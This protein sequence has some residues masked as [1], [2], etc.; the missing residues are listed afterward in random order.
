MKYEFAHACELVDGEIRSCMGTGLSVFSGCYQNRI[1]RNRL[2]T[3][4]HGAIVVRGPQNP[5]DGREITRETRIS[6]NQLYDCGGINIHASYTLM[7][8]ISHNYIT[9]TRGRFA[10]DVGG[11]RNLEEA[12]DGGY[13]VEYNHLEDVQQDAD[14]SGAV[15]T[16][17]MT[18]NSVV[19]RNLVHQ[20]NAGFFND[21][22]AFWFDN[23]SVGWTAEENIYYNLEQGEWKLCAATIEII[24][25]EITLP[26][27]PESAPEL[28]IEGEPRLKRAI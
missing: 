18:F 4:D 3:I 5:K 6:Y 21:N 17:G 19:R 8:T 26:L 28:I 20:V 27:A 7:T 13:L 25:I 15:K 23:M 1:L 10:I 14:D 16:A 24:L 11:W 9:G 2:E 12:I 22:V